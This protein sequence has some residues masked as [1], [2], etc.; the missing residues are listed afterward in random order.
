MPL[1]VKVMC[2]AYAK[3]FGLLQKFQGLFAKVLCLYI[4]KSLAFSKKIIFFLTQISL[5]G[6]RTIEST[7]FTMD[8][9][10][11]CKT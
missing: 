1:F 10:G 4:H 5:M 3:V 11:Q 8:T 9:I 2:F 7:L 6:F